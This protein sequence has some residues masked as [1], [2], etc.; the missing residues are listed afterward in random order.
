MNSETLDY[1]CHYCGFRARTPTELWVHECEGK[2]KAK[3][4][5]KQVIKFGQENNV[6]VGLSE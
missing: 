2:R 5:K 6:M 1:E 3:Q 4:F